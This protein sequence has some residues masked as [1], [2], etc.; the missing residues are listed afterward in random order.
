[1][2]SKQHGRS[3][4]FSPSMNRNAVL[5][6]SNKKGTR[7]GYNRSKIYFLPKH[8]KKTTTKHKYQTILFLASKKALLEEDSVIISNLAHKARGVADIVLFDLLLAPIL[9]D[10]RN[11]FRTSGSWAPIDSTMASIAT[12]VVSKPCGDDVTLFPFGPKKNRKCCQLEFWG[13]AEDSHVIGSLLPVL[14]ATSLGK[15]SACPDE[16]NSISRIMAYIFIKEK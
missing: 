14:N 10:H 15:P 2:V 6:L 1:M 9:I 7:I 12:G 16:G 4:T 3:C 8:K 13:G 5:F 11:A